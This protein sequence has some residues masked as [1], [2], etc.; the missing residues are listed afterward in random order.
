MSN[1]GKKLVIENIARQK[2]T[3]YDSLKRAFAKN[4]VLYGIKN[5][6]QSGG[7]HIGK[8]L[9]RDNA[10]LVGLSAESYFAGEMKNKIHSELLKETGF[11]SISDLE[12][13]LDKII[14]VLPA[15]ETPGGTTGGSS[16]SSGKTSLSG[17]VS[18][19]VSE[20]NNIGNES[21]FS[22]VDDGHWAK[23][24]IEELYKR[25]IVNGYP[26]NTF[27][28]DDRVTREQALKMILCAAEYEPAA[29]SGSFFDVDKSAWYASYIGAALQ[30]NI[31]RGVGENMFGIGKNVT[32]EDFAVMMYRAVGSPESGEG[33][34]FTD[35]ADIAD[36]AVNAVDYM[37]FMKYIS[38]YG[39]GSFKPKK[40]ITRAE[41]AMIIYKFLGGESV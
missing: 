29:Y 39:D 30:R 37:S 41:A 24:A 8:L 1:D 31:V 32:R 4:V 21:V 13:K 15:K 5:S 18:S 20:I 7:E 38:G 12:E 33:C 3:D 23:S 34:V 27:C 17:P 6:A 26:D 11:L 35:K 9:T 40:T 14:K 25:G 22:D 2:P 16:S 19:M 28:P 10:D 36:Y